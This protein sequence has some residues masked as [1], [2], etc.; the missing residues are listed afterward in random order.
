MDCSHSLAYKYNLQEQVYKNHYLLGQIAAVQGNLGNATRHY[1]AAIAQFERALD[2]LE[3]AR[4]M[5]LRR[6][7]STGVTCI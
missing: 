5:T 4:S 1:G 2:Y 6:V 7:P 3:R